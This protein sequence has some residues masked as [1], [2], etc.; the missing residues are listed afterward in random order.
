MIR[1]DDLEVFVN[2]AHSGSFSAA[3]RGLDITPAWA[4]GAVQ[5]LERELGSRLFV[6]STR[7]MRLSEEGERYLPHAE[8]VLAAVAEGRQALVRPGAEIAG[9]L[10][11]SMPSD[12]GRNIVLPWLDEFQ[13]LYPKI[14]LHLRVSDHMADFFQQA[15]DAGLRYGQLSDSSLVALPI[16]PDN[17]RVLCASPDYVAR[18]GR[19]RT[20][21]DLSAHNCLRF[22]L[23]EQTYERWKFHLPEGVKTIS[24]K[25]DRLSDD[26]EL[27]RRWAVDGL[28]VAYKSRID[29]LPDLKAGRLV[30]L[31]PPQYGDP[32]PLQLIAAHRASISPVINQLR[33]FLVEKFDRLLERSG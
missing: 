6:R 15:L 19:P 32:V 5:R 23:K 21:D 29:F 20:P 12:L 10:R 1:I 25:G 27:V 31:F 11:I 28:G 24:V 3:A 18:H 30:E 7:K 14:T 2:A 4:S 16:A 33:D 17:R 9:P 26:A 22:V 8:A 13:R